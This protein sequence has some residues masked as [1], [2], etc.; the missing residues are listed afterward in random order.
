MV[1]KFE[2]LYA[3]KSELQ[4]TD[5]QMHTLLK[6]ITPSAIPDLFAFSDGYVSFLLRQNIAFPFTQTDCYHFDPVANW[7]FEPSLTYL[8][9]IVSSPVA[10]LPPYE[11]WTISVMSTPD[12]ITRGFTIRRDHPLDTIER[13]QA[14][15]E[16]FRDR[17]WKYFSYP[18][19]DHIYPEQPPPPS[20]PPTI[21]DVIVAPLWNTI[22]AG[23]TVVDDAEIKRV[24]TE[25][26]DF[27]TYE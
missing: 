26:L 14:A 10:I 25:E 1:T 16:Q 17:Q 19:L 12:L 13:R 15:V 9:T 8:D 23:Y 3:L 24:Y 6:N 2:W 11:D 22:I 7:S 18:P 4:T 20:Q 27:N 21:S 5:Q